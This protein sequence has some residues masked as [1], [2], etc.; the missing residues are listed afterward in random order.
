MENSLK[1]ASK[2]VCL[3]VVEATGA[4]CI[5]FA[6]VRIPIL[7]KITSSM[8]DKVIAAY[9]YQ[10]IMGLANFLSIAAG[11]C[12]G[13]TLANEILEH[14]K[15]IPGINVAATTAAALSTAALHCI[16][17]AFL[18]CACELMKKGKITDKELQNTAFCKSLCANWMKNAGNI[19]LKVIRG[20]N[21]VE[22]A[23]I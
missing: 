5:P 23:Y 2:A 20:Y 21:P 4:A 1:K 6:A 10:S 15:C 22:L 14:M 19:V 12:A 17:G 13:V 3:S 18:I 7:T 8:S 11:A 16:T 9:G